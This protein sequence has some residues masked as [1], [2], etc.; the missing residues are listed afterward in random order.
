MGIRITRIGVPF[1]KRRQR[2]GFI[3]SPD[4]Q[5]LEGAEMIELLERDN[6]RLRKALRRIAEWKTDNEHWQDI[7]EKALK[8]A[9][10]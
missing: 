2:R 5:G 1:R 3:T 4:G 7:A 6:M 8:A 10:I 9:V